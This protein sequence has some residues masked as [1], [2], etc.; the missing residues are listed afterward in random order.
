[1][2]SNHLSAIPLPAAALLRELGASV[3]T[4]NDRGYPA[5]LRDLRDAPPFLTVLGGLPL[6][7]I[8]IVG[9]R[10]PPAPAAKFAFELARSAGMPVISGLATGIDTAAHRGA[11]A[12]GAA[13]LAYVGS[14]LACVYPLENR[15]LA[16]DIVAAGGGLASEQLPDR[17]VT[18]RALIRRDRL[19]AAHARAVV[20]ICSEVDGGAMHTMRFAKRLQRPRF[21]LSPQDGAAYDGNRLGLADGAAPLSWDV[22]EAVHALVAARIFTSNA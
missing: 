12:A 13:T 19:Q 20:L 15:S 3:I 9:S 22:G 18:Q 10:T 1:M 5:G 14:G 2:N 8:A 7:G 11:L 4:I 6:R 16:A 17:A 21:V